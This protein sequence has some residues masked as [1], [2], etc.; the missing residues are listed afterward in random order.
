MDQQTLFRL[1]DEPARIAECSTVSLE[2][3]V[4]QYPWAPTFQLLLT[5]KY[6][7][8][9]DAG[10]DE[11]L[12][13][14]AVVVPD[15]QRLF[16]LINE[17]PQDIAHEPGDREKPHFGRVQDEE[18]EEAAEAQQ[19]RNQEEPTHRQEQDEQQQQE[20]EPNEPVVPLEETRAYHQFMKEFGIIEEGEE[21]QEQEQEQEKEKATAP[22][23]Q[24]EQGHESQ[25][26][27]RSSGEA[28]ESDEAVEEAPVQERSSTH[29][30]TEWLS[31]VNRQTGKEQEG[32]EQDDPKAEQADKPDWPHQHEEIPKEE[33]EEVS[34][35]AE[36]SVELNDEAVSQTLAQIYAN[37]KKYVKAISI[38]EKLRL[39]YPEKSGFFAE[40]IQELKQN[41]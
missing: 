19:E 25:P 23:S 14:S 9:G 28:P 37:Q 35:Q 17:S 32:G 7:L 2:Q 8:S 41:L 34:Q 13:R 22:E 18:Q 26:S 33:M 12:Q 15:R 30:F 20:S 39:K 6:Q 1:L 16:T 5:K 11:Q 4:K 10:F 27:N 38:Y 3:L 29:T 36:K 21:K 24:K 31:L 40:K